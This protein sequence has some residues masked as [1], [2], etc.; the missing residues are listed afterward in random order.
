MIVIQTIVEENSVKYSLL[1]HQ[2][3]QSSTALSYRKQAVTHSED[4]KMVFSV[5]AAGAERLRA[6]TLTRES[7]DALV[8]GTEEL[9]SILTCPKLTGVAPRDAYCSLFNS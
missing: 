3:E 6:H 7:L 2:K 9:T 8:P 1:I 4:R 5:E